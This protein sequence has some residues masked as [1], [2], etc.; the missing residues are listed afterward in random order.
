MEVRSLPANP[1]S[2]SPKFPTLQ[3]VHQWMKLKAFV[4]K[5]RLSLD[6]STHHHKMEYYP[7]IE[8]AK[9]KNWSL[10]KIPGSCRAN[11]NNNR[12][13]GGGRLTGSLTPPAHSL[14][15]RIQRRM[16]SSG[17]TINPGR[18][19]PTL[20]QSPSTTPPSNTNVVSPAI[21]RT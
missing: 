4:S 16:E 6:A 13:S 1:V 14:E 21:K 9:N 5:I 20:H 3:L 2:G 11:N 8:P 19:A 17:T 7:A 15:R 12:Q 10:L 18:M